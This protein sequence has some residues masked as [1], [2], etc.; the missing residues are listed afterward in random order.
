MIFIR[1]GDRP[2]VMSVYEALTL[3]FMKKWPA[4]VD[5]K[6]PPKIPGWIKSIRL[7]SEKTR[8]QK[9]KSPRAKQL[10]LKG[11]RQSR[12]I[13][14]HPHSPP[15]GNEVAMAVPGRKKL[16]IAGPLELNHKLIDSPHF[17]SLRVCDSSFGRVQRL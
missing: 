17:E 2:Q 8:L 4:K 10:L 13:G 5:K 12:S 16:R 3:R 15:H 1:G 6:Y 11:G 9:G 14:G 7:Q